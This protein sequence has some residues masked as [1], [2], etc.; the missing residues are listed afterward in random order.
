MSREGRFLMCAPAHYGVEYVINPWMAGNVHRVARD[1]AVKQ[2][3]ALSENLHELAEVELVEP[4]PGLPDMVFT[5]N[6]GFVMERRAVLTRFFHRERQDERQHFKKWFERRGFEVVELPDDVPFEGEGDALL[7]RERG[8]LWMGY[9]L[10]TD[11]GAHPMLA[12]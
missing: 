1:I 9:G 7:D 11:L 4:R 5:A 8:F 2:W 3:Q 6:G 12:E 10:R